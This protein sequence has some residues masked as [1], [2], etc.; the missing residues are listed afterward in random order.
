MKS[1]A[2][3]KKGSQYLGDAIF[4]HVCANL[5]DHLMYYSDY[6][7][8]SDAEYAYRRFYDEEGTADFLISEN[9]IDMST[10]AQLYYVDDEGKLKYEK[11]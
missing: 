3:C 7:A 8:L 2:K 10:I 11:S 1:A 6:Q 5:R 4:V 9:D